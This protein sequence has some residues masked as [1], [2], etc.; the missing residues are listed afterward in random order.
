MANDLDSWPGQRVSAC[1]GALRPWSV[2]LSKYRE[3]CNLRAV[4]EI[5]VTAGSFAGLWASAWFATWV[6][7]WLA[8][9]ISLTAAFF[10]VR[11]FMI[12]HDC[13]HGAL[14]SRRS[15]NDWAGRVI[16]VLTLTP[17]DCWRRDHNH[18]HAGAGNLDRRGIGDVT[19]LTVHEYRSLTRWAQ[20]KYRLYRHPLVM[21]GIAPV[22]LFV[23]Q[24]RIPGKSERHSTFAWATTIATNA[25][26]ICVMGGMIAVVGLIPFLAVQAPL[27]IFSATIGVW[28]FYVQHQFEVTYWARPPQWTA[29]AAALYGSSY[30]LMPRP[31]NWLTA[32][33]GLHHIHHLSS[34]I[35]F[36]R[37]PNVLKDWPEL[38]CARCLTIAESV[39]SLKLALWDE[40][41]QRLVSFKR[42][43]V[44]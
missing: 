42:L 27:T 9:L 17:Y 36:Y 43:A 8:I 3:R 15:A 13:G 41:S 37:L 22:F 34:G 40:A 16:G 4:V 23:V 19:T 28:L 30:L 39:R 32:N 33:I 18:H 11:L 14:F 5:V 24:H 31:L 20:F 25:A 38:R 35:P 2:E 1:D 6:S 26:T 44:Q 7:Y 12:Q 10:L 29:E 21:L